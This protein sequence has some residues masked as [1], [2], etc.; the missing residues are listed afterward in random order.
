MNKRNLIL[1]ITLVLIILTAFFIIQAPIWLNNHKNPFGIASFNIEWH[2]WIR[3]YRN[4]V[5]LSETYHVMTITTYGQNQIEQLLGDN[6]DLGLSYFAV[7]NNETAVSTSW[8]ELPNEVTSNG[9]E[10]AAATYASTGTGTWTMTKTWTA[11]GTQSCCLYGVYSNTYAAGQTTLCLAEQQGASA[12]K[13]LI[14]GDTLQMQ[15]AG[16]VS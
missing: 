15:V 11:T 8:T 3:H 10:R 16:T 14:S 6:S 7:S 9:L 5:L 13:N 4:G 1:P 12:R 2:C